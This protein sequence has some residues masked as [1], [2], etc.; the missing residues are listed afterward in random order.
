MLPVM[1]GPVAPPSAVTAERLKPSG[2]TT[3]LNTFR[4]VTGPIAA[5]DLRK[6]KQITVKAVGKESFMVEAGS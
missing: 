6:R 5:E 4:S 1:S 2:L 3:E